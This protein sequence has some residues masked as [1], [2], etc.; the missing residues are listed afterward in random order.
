MIIEEFNI[1]IK[2]MNSTSHNLEPKRITNSNVTIIHSTIYHLEPKQIIISNAIIIL[3]N[4]L[5]IPVY[6]HYGKNASW[7]FQAVHW[8]IYNHPGYPIA[9]DEI[10]D[11]QIIRIVLLSLIT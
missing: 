7:R 6:R 10:G 3:Q 1:D 11:L 5:R 4:N 8:K 9:L 2:I